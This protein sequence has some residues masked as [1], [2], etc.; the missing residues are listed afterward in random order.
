MGSLLSVKVAKPLETVCEGVVPKIDTAVGIRLVL[1]S[2]S[3]GL[4]SNQLDLM[5]SY[6]LLQM[7]KS[8]PVPMLIL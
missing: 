5:E 4:S 2:I 3:A 7:I 6:L 1:R 8:R